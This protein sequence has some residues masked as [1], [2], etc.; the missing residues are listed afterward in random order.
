MPG[1]SSSVPLNCTLSPSSDAGVDLQCGARARVV[2]RHADAAPARAARDDVERE[3]VRPSPAR[4][5]SPCQRPAMSAALSSAAFASDAS[6]IAAAENTNCAHHYFQHDV[7]RTSLTHARRHDHSNARQANLCRA[8][9]PFVAQ[10]PR[11]AVIFLVLLLAVPT[12]L[13]AVCRGRR[14]HAA[15]LQSVPCRPAP[16]RHLQAAHARFRRRL[17]AHPARPSPCAATGAGTS[18]S[19]VSPPSM[20]VLGGLTSLPVAFYSHS[21]AMA[22]AGF[23]A[24]G[25]VWLTLIALGV[26]AVRAGASSPTTPRLM[27][28][29]AAVASGALWVR[30]DDR[31]RDPRRPAVRSGLRLRRLARAGWSR[32][33][34]S[35]CCRCPTRRHA[36]S[37]RLSAPLRL[38]CRA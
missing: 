16:A 6:G 2:L 4:R 28:A 29:M 26:T 27:L 15:A 7:P 25:V 20:V 11:L 36:A 8:S 9:A 18:R 37:P 1:A 13:V 17:V 35:R 30:L 23:F 32:S 10:T 38:I 33:P 24:Q 22:R 19:D 31:G 3:R 5:L 34:S 21:V 14:A 12:G